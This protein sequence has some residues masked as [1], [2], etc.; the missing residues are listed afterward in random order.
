MKVTLKVNVGFDSEFLLMSKELEASFITGKCI[1]EVLKG[2][3]NTMNEYIKSM[4][5]YNHKVVCVKERDGAFALGKVYKVT[6]GTITGDNGID[7][8]G[9]K[10]LEDLNDKLIAQFIE[11]KGEA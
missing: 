1:A 6:N 7:Y 10:S 5:Q 9:I 3:E 2:L 11:F 4:E 8:C